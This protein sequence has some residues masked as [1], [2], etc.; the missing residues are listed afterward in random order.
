MEN[1]LEDM[2]VR[3]GELCQQKTAAKILSVTPRTISRMMDAGKLRR[4]GTH[5]DVRSIHE[6]IECPQKVN[7][8]VRV[9]AR[10]PM[11]TVSRGEFF[12]ASMHRGL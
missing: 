10:A 1:R 9:K 8:E 12:A 11:N 4:V 6:Y 2:L 3:Y 7:F 5:V